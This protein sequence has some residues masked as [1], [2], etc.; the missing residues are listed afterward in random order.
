MEN[1]KI[2]DKT[3]VAIVDGNA[4]HREAV[5]EV[6]SDYYAVNTYGDSTN[7]LMGLCVSPPG[8]VL[9]GEGVPPSSGVNFLRAMRRE[10]QLWYTPVIYVSDRGDI[11]TLQIALSA[12]ASDC[13][14][15]P[16]RRSALVRAVS[17]QLNA[18][19][20][21][22]WKKLLPFQRDALEGTLSV[23]NSIA[24]AIDA[25]SP[26]QYLAVAEACSALVEAV[27]ANRHQPILDAVRDH[28]NYAYVHS[29][30]VATLL[31]RFGCLIGLSRS[32]L[33]LLTAGGLLHDVGKLAIRHPAVHKTEVLTSEEAE[34]VRRHVAASV[35]VLRTS[36]QMP[37]GVVTI[38]LQH[39]ERLDGSGYPNGLSGDKLNELAR[40]AGI[41]DAFV[42][43]TDPRTMSGGLGPTQAVRVMA[44]DQE[45]QFDQEL[46]AR[47]KD[48]VS[49]TPTRVTAE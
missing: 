13:M 37:K 19:V 16:Y 49:Q 7:A 3:L 8:L 35:A 22:G 23:F 30:R 6:L 11:E 27:D 17:V 34:I 28:D 47:F 31:A 44:V 26:I 12:G 45:G 4:R 9:I 24:D 18:K 1:A 36:E 29:L 43:L 15:K 41:V 33:L 5:A 10:R 25:D 14:L 42:T 48:V 32:Q 2:A 46:L 21:Q 38:A 20:E 39:H 40:M